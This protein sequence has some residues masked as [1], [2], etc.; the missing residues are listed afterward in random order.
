MQEKEAELMTIKLGRTR[1][2]LVN[3]GSR[4]LIVQERVLV[5]PRNK[6]PYHKWRDYA[7]FNKAEQALL[8]ALNQSFL[9]SQAKSFEE[10]RMDLMAAQNE[11]IEAIRGLEAK[12]EKEAK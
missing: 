11:I 7:F 12:N 1:F 9:R 4:N 3:D 2:R 10:L 8:W 5:K 6:E